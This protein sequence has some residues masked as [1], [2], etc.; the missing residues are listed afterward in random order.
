MIVITD[1][2]LNGQ[3]DTINRQA[4]RS[5]QTWLPIKPFGTKLWLGPIIKPGHSACWACFAHRIAAN[6]QIDNYFLTRDNKSAPLYLTTAAT[7]TSKEAAWNIAALQ[8]SK[9]LR[10]GSSDVLVDTLWEFDIL[11]LESTKHKVIRRPQCTTC[12]T[13]IN[14]LQGDDFKIR[15]M[16][17]PKLF[18]SDGGHRTEI[19]EHTF[20][21][22]ESL[23]SPLTG[24]VT[25]LSRTSL[26]QDE[27][28]VYSFSAGHNFALMNTNPSFLIK[29]LRGRSGGK[30]MTEMQAKVSALCEAVERYSG[31]FWG[32][33]VNIKNTYNDLGDS[34]IH[35]NS[36]MLFSDNQFANRNSWNNSHRSAFHKVPERFNSA[37]V[38]SWS[39][40]W[41]LTHDTVRYVPSAY[42]FYGHP[43]LREKFFCTCDANGNAAG[44][45]IEEA[46]LQ[47]LLELVERDS[48]A[49]WWYN[50]VENRSIIDL[51]SFDNPYFDKMIT[52]YSSINREIWALD[53]TSDLGI[54]TVAMIS[55]RMDNKV[56]DILLGFGCHLDPEMAIHR[57]L[58]E[59]NQ[60]LP[61]V[62]SLNDD[63]STIYWFDDEDALNWWKTATL[64]DN[65]YLKTMN[66]DPKA[67]KDSLPNLASNDLK[68]DIHTCIEILSK[69]D[70]EV[71]VLDQTRPDINLC[72]AKVMVPGLRHFWK[73]FGPGRIFDVPVSMNW[74]SFPLSENKLNPVGIFF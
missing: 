31:V 61:A 17:R 52:F 74:R 60:F 26:D 24:V 43:E 3:L 66:P 71:L 58:T 70:L 1:D 10:D 6:R 69:K 73:R 15:L 16:N 20:R 54:P 59:V 32:D 9:F 30:G 14:K 62:R 19:P 47:G 39:S 29:N 41:S 48:V 65:L 42:C 68:V 23:I 34:A 21:K 11:S 63:G 22:Y 12:G 46:I 8:I 57:A 28:F 25:S 35:P 38:I 56:E 33:E 64:T 44:N 50:K 2:Y 51:S 37:Q 67:T 45:T 40:V 18:T 7:Q 53:I 55:R 36:L 27:G 5:K 4:L 72:V 49:L 13:P